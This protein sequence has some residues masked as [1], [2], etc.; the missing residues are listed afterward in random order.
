MRRLLLLA[1]VVLALSACDVPVGDTPSQTAA[2]SGALVPTAVST[3]LTVSARDPAGTQTERT[4]TARTALV[5]GHLPAN[6]FA[7]NKTDFAATVNASGLDASKKAELIAGANS[8]FDK[9]ESDLNAAFDGVPR[10]MTLVLGNRVGDLSS[11]R[12]DF[13][14]KAN[15]AFSMDGLYNTATTEFALASI[16]FARGDGTSQAAIVGLSGCAFQ[17][18]LNR[19]TATHGCSATGLLV[20]QNA[21]AIGVGLNLTLDLG[22]TR[23]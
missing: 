1:T 19:T 7:Q 17:G 2:L 5:N 21:G 11:A 20:V 18:A 23:D 10:R 6:P 9:L 4:W 13:R 22:F 3:S 16:G 12:F 8:A 14:T 15:A